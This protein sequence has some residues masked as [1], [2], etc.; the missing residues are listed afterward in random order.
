MV[1]KILKDAVDYTE[2]LKQDT[3]ACEILSCIKFYTKE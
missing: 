1:V 3:L 2:N